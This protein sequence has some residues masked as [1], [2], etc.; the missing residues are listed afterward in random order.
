MKPR[1]LDELQTYDLAFL[2]DIVAWEDGP[3]D[4]NAALL[5]LLASPEIAQK[6]WIWRQYDHQ[7]LTNTVVGPGSD[8]AVLRIKEAAPS[9]IAVATDGDG[10]KTYLDPFAG[11]ALAVAE[12]TR[13][14]AC[15]GARP[16]AITDCLNFGNPERLDVYF[17]LEECVR[18]MAAACEMLGV[19][20]VSGNVSLFN[21]SDGEAIYPT[22]VVGA[23]GVLDDVSKAVASG[24]QA[25]GD[26][27]YLIGGVG[28]VRDGVTLVGDASQ[29]AGSEYLRQFHG[30]I[31]GSV[32][33]ELA[34]EARLQQVLIQAASEAMLRSAHDCSH[35]GLA[36]TLAEACMYHGIGFATEGLEIDGR[37]DAALFGETASRVVVSL[38]RDHV[39]AFE[40][41]L[42][43]SEVPFVRLGETGGE[44]LRLAGT[45]D[46][47]LD[48]L[49]AAYEGGLEAALTSSS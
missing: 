38:S 39:G 9:G 29:L 7:V 33:I 40:A 11:G 3:A 32:R 4:A 25:E 18:G 8:A 26:A 43:R 17:Q 27:V 12:A 35:G 23:L 16:V 31:A 15:S 49:S 2:P 48:E 13:N 6:R 19:P 22:P 1:G 47:P 21:E 24:F 30:L 10:V 44:R 46:L 45:I 28:E 42:E 34:L 37:R 20:V 14:V 36:V 41:L 5:Q